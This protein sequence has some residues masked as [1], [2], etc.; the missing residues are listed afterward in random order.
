MAGKETAYEEEMEWDYK[1]KEMEE[2][3]DVMLDKSFPMFLFSIHFGISLSFP[4]LNAVDERASLGSIL[5][6]CP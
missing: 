1:W 6:S 2:K 4:V 5:S 3:T